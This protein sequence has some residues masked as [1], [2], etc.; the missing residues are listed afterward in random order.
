MHSYTILEPI[1]VVEPTPPWNRLRIRLFWSLESPWIRLQKIWN[2]YISSQFVSGDC[3]FISVF[4]ISDDLANYMTMVF[5]PSAQF[6][7]SK[8]Q[9]MVSNYS[10]NLGRLEDELHSAMDVHNKTYVE[11]LDSVA[12]RYVAY[13]FSTPL[14]DVFIMKCPQVSRDD[15][16]MHFPQP[17]TEG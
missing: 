5:D 11:L 4:N 9:R 14:I 3:H 10:E 8:M 13:N 7:N 2:R 16:L 1:L 17:G 6:I 12:V 15:S